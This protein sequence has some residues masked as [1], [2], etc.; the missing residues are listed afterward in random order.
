MINVNKGKINLKGNKLLIRAELTT[1]IHALFNS[2][3][4]TKE[5]IEK[6][7]AQG[8][9]TDDKLI[10]TEKELENKLGSKIDKLLKAFLND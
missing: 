10:K 5:E 3:I 6:D 7:V 4:L 1:L 9:M 2:N 8:F